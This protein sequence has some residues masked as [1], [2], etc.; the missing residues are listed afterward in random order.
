M[1]NE[2]YSNAAVERIVSQLKLIK[3]IWGIPWLSPTLVSVLHT[4]YALKKTGVSA[5]DVQLNPDLL[6]TLKSIK[7]NLPNDEFSTKIR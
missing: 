2:Y 3:L 7:S 1:V 6:A 4:K 5:H